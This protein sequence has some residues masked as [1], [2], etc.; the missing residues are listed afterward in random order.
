MSVGQ[1]ATPSALSYIAIARETVFGT[2]VTGTAQLGFL[3]SSIKT[4]QENK[5]LE[6]IETSR[7]Y[8][9]NIR[10]SKQIEGDIEYYFA[11]R[12]TATGWLLENAF[13]AAPTSATSTGETVGGGAFTHTFAIGHI[14]DAS[15]PSLSINYRKG[16]ASSGQVFEYFGTRINEWKLT[17]EIDDAVKSSVSLICKN[18]TITT[19][20]VESSLSVTNNSCLSFVDGRISVETTFA[21]LT[22]T[23]FWHV[24]SVEF[25][26]A[27][28]LKNGN[29]SRRVG[30]DVLDV[31]P[32]GIAS[33]TFNATIRF[34]TTTA[35]LA[36]RNSTQLSGQLEFL[37]DTMAGSTVREGLTVN[38]PKL[39]ISDAGDP[40]V[41]GPDE[42]L[43]SDVVFHV[44][45]DTSSATGYAVKALLTNNI[46]SYA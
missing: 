35:Y 15:Y 24:Q 29:E 44:L 31:L 43:T 9:K 21:G 20:D 6:S 34:D 41:G 18:E 39:F 19:N 22:S 23:S 14:V 11:P 42:I 38:L 4:I 17:A 32:S 40:E 26:V 45:R 12:E 5:I 33:F 1:G 16:D 13:G 46:A 3:S 8:S 25:A 28:S 37:G 30:S 36:M 7:T 27:N 2:G 10:M